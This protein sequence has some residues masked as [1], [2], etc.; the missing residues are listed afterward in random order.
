MTLTLVRHGETDWNVQKRIQGCTDIPLNDNGILQAH[1]LGEKLLRDV[2]AGIVPPYTQLYA[3]SLKRAFHTG[4]II[5]TYLGLSCQ[6]LPGLEEIAF[7]DW[8]GVSWEQVKTNF[9]DAY[10]VWYQQRRHTR[11]PKGESYQDLLNRVLPALQTVLPREQE[12]IL[13]VSHS[14]ILMSLMSF[15]HD[16]PFQDMHRN[17][18]TKNTGTISLTPEQMQKIQR[19]HLE[20]VVL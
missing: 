8:E 7:G 18:K 19:Y 3:S 20:N 16:T 4:E 11:P 2:N 9:P 10:Q 14:A 17:Y 5:G 15:L 12:H 13:I 1:Q 6:P